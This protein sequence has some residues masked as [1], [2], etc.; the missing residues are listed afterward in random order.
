MVLNEHIILR[1][2]VEQHITSQLEKTRSISLPKLNAG[3]L[4]FQMLQ[5][6]GWAGGPIGKNSDGIAEPVELVIYICYSLYNPFTYMVHALIV[7]CSI[8]IKSNR[9]GLGTK[10]HH[11]TS[12]SSLGYQHIF[13]FLRHFKLKRTD[14]A[15]MLLRHDFAPREHNL[16]K[17]YDS[18]IV[19]CLR[20]NNI[21]YS[22]LLDA[23]GDCSSNSIWVTITT[24]KYWRFASLK[25]NPKQIASVLL[26]YYYCTHTEFKLKM[27][28]IINNEIFELCII[29]SCSHI[30]GTKKCQYE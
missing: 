28:N 30:D 19:G 1:T 16:F 5:K 18:L 27:N 23:V 20:R 21:Y 10:E 29:L 7:Y 8:N 3:N 26:N 11:R 25:Y 17:A 22:L 13:G 15:V 4:G 9:Y 12:S 6:Q 24:D 2:D 14:V